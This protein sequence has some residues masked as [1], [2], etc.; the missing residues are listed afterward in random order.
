MPAPSLTGS[1]HCPYPAPS[2]SARTLR[3]FGRRGPTMHL[4]PP[5]NV[6]SWRW[7]RPPIRTAASP[8]SAL[9]SV[10]PSIYDRRGPS[11][12]PGNVG[13]RQ[14]VV[15]HEHAAQF[16]AA[17]ELGE[18]LAGIEQMVGIEGALH[19]HLLVEV[20]LGEL[21]AHQV[22]LL[23]ADAVFAGQHAAHAHAEPQDVG[24]ELLG[25]SQF[26]GIVGVEQDQRMEVAV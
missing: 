26:A 19:P 1:A 6:S 5:S 7:R 21:F 11:S 15:M 23:D 24:A 12:K 14:L 9:P 3:S 8:C 20:D 18:H 16:G 22:A 2:A 4:P 13:E 25:A 10:H 17:P